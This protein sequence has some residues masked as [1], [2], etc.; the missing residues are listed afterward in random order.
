M[1]LT[2]PYKV[3]RKSREK[4]WLGPNYPWLGHSS[5][6]AKEDY[7]HAIET[8]II[9]ESNSV[10]GASFEAETLLFLILVYFW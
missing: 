5:I 4:E 9:C 3:D 1:T 7:G 10:Q 8:T 6:N 2:L